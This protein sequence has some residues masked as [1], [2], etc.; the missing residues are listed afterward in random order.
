[1]FPSSLS[2]LFGVLHVLDT[3]EKYDPIVYRAHA[4]Y[5]SMKTNP[6]SR[7][8]QLVEQQSYTF[9]WAACMLVGIPN[10]ELSTAA[11]SSIQSMNYTALIG[12]TL[13]TFHLEHV[14]EDTMMLLNGLTPV[15]LQ[16]I[17]R[18]RLNPEFAMNLSANKDALI[19]SNLLSPLD[20]QALSNLTKVSRGMFTPGSFHSLLIE[21][22]RAQILKAPLT[23]E[24]SAFDRIMPVVMLLWDMAPCTFPFDEDIL[25]WL[26]QHQ[27]NFL[28]AIADYL[29]SKNRSHAV[30]DSKYFNFSDSLYCKLVTTYSFDQV[31]TLLQFFFGTVPNH[32]TQE[33]IILRAIL[34]TSYE[35]CRK[36][37][38]KDDLRGYM[39]ILL[40]KEILQVPMETY[41][42]LF[43]DADPLASHDGLYI[44]E[45]AL[46]S[47]EHIRFFMRNPS[48]SK[49]HTGLFEH[50]VEYQ[51]VDALNAFVDYFVLEHTRNMVYETGMAPYSIVLEPC[52]KSFDTRIAQFREEVKDETRIQYEWI[53]KETPLKFVRTYAISRAW[54]DGRIDEAIELIDAVPLRMVS[55]AQESSTN[56]LDLWETIQREPVTNVKI[57]LSRIH[58]AQEFFYEKVFASYMKAHSNSVPKFM[59]NILALLSSNVIRALLQDIPLTISWNDFGDL[60]SRENFEWMTACLNRFGNTLPRRLKTEGDDDGVYDELYYLTDK[61]ILDYWIY[62]RAWM[63]VLETFDLTYFELLLKST[64][65]EEEE[66]LRVP[67]ALDWCISR[68]IPFSCDVHVSIEKPVIASRIL[69]YLFLRLKGIPDAVQ[70]YWDLLCIHY[71]SHALCLIENIQRDR[72]EITIPNTS[73]LFSWGLLRNLSTRNE[74]VHYALLVMRHFLKNG[75]HFMLPSVPPFMNVRDIFPYNL[76]LLLLSQYPEHIVTQCMTLHYITYFQRKWA[77]L[78]KEKLPTL[79]HQ[80]NHPSLPSVRNMK[81]R[82]GDTLLDSVSNVRPHV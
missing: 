7:S 44:D 29:K 82:A 47:A 6:L 36:W 22:A 3:E 21:H 23:P 54:D 13:T 62:E 10:A 42:K 53:Y 5:H 39:A 20:V 12:T 45:N 26:I 79:Y 81:K 51:M 46:L 9:E 74:V 17:R 59:E 60:D 38:H 31:Q 33:T 41:L 24:P 40:S 18:Q 67:E 68:K 37:M 75:D 32:M 25:R 8:V 58:E 50:L 35:E 77:K 34:S 19:R 1:M 4:T 69:N 49:I 72:P 2:E 80:F 57:S 76:V 27:P 78:S 11:L 56:V 30:R 52:L 64:V 15:A 71:S 55:I 43:P 61:K 16:I 14:S 28:L 70:Q 48:T 65:F 66:D 73:R 63:P